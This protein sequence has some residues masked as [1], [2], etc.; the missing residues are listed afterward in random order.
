MNDHQPTT[1]PNPAGQ[2]KTKEYFF[3]AVLL[4]VSCALHGLGSTFPSLSSFTSGPDTATLGA[5]IVTWFLARLRN[6]DK[7]QASIDSARLTNIEQAIWSIDGMAQQMRITHAGR[8]DAHDGQ[9]KTHDM[10]LDGNE[11]LL[12]EHGE[13]IDELNKAAASHH[14]HILHLHDGIKQVNPQ[15][16]PPVAIYRNPNPK[17]A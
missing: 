8:L 9:L 17:P 7:G 16:N 12:N 4:I 10:R 6:T 14:Q 3:P 1:P 13:Q 11:F 15:Y 2:S 5:T